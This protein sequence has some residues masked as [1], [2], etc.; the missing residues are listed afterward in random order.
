MVSKNQN[1]S[2]RDNPPLITAA[3]ISWNMGPMIIEAMV[4]VHRN[5]YPNIEFICIDDASTDGVSQDVLSEYHRETN[6]GTLI[7]NQVNQGVAKNLNT[8][9]S[10]ARGKYL[11]MLGDDLYRP[12]K[13]WADVE[14]F[15]SLPAEVAVVH[16]IIQQVKSDGI[17]KFP[18][19]SPT[20]PWP[21]EV[22]D[23]LEFRDIL[24]LGGDFL[25]APTA[26]HKVEHVR[27][28]GGWDEDLRNEDV[29]MWFR[30][31]NAGFTFHFRPEVTVDY[32][33]HSGQVSS[34]F[35]LGDFV[36]W[37][38]V[39]RPYGHVDVSQRKMRGFLAY[40]V[41]AS[42]DGVSDWR[43]CWAIYRSDP[44]HSRFYSFLIRTRV[45]LT[46]AAL[47]RVTRR[48]ARRG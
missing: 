15:E 39:Y 19:F 31:A 21:Q 30:L 47:F 1:V 18:S 14:A 23:D 22:R 27:S 44:N 12:E 32:R 36:Y 3:M 11:F 17:S 46:A 2:V 5:N 20:R 45:L 13:L 6:F 9:L 16:S 24:A 43:E 34:G 28:V 48:L 33:R 41:S 25:A 40:A 10:K 42:L 7:L 8:V 35:K 37:M 26:L 38:K 4:S 29:G